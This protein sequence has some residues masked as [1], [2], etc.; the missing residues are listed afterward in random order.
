MQS[1]S[2]SFDLLLEKYAHYRQIDLTLVILYT[3]TT[4]H[5]VYLDSEY[6]IELH[7]KALYHLQEVLKCYEPIVASHN[8]NYT[9]SYFEG[10]I[11]SV[12]SILRSCENKPISL[13]VPVLHLCEDSNDFYWNQIDNLI[14]STVKYKSKFNLIAEVQGDLVSERSIKLLE[15][16]L[17][18][19]LVN[20]NET[21]FAEQ[22][23]K[24][25]MEYNLKMEEE[26]EAKNVPLRVLQKD[27]DTLQIKDKEKDE[28][29]STNLKESLTLL[30][31]LGSLTLKEGTKKNNNNKHDHILLRK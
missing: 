4:G 20:I 3:P 16:R 24:R 27:N 7:K 17:P 23:N 14:Q 6:Y 18:Y 19:H 1:I 29:G 28:I 11:K 5:T 12:G 22:G 21:W 26:E 9:L 8:N 31:A 25:L 13:S 15:T 10:R 30:G 2:E